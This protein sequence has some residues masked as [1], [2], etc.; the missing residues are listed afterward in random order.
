MASPIPKLP[1]FIRCADLS[2]SKG[3][4][5]GLGLLMLSF[6]L[7]PLPFMRLTG[8]P[9]ALRILLPLALREWLAL[10]PPAVLLLDRC[11]PLS[12]SFTAFFDEEGV[13]V[14]TGDE[15]VAMVP[16]KPALEVGDLTFGEGE[17][18]PVIGQWVGDT[19]AVDVM[20][21]VL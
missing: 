4:S 15:D 16:S 14:K 9:M 10:R 21:A 7:F 18:L 12:T 11:G 19:G 6:L 13:A 17:N 20:R 1:P 2:I 3:L 5:K 8:K